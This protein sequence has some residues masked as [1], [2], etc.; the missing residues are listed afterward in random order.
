MGPDD[1]AG[2][3]AVSEDEISQDYQSRAAEFDIPEK[4]HLEQTIFADEASAKAAADQIK[5][6][7]SVADAARKATGKPPGDIGMVAKNEVLPAL[8]G[9]FDAPEGGVTGPVQPALGWHLTHVVKIQPAHKATLAEVHDKVKADI[10]RRKAVDAL[11]SLT[12]Q[13]DDDLASGDT[14]EK[15]AEK[16]RLKV[17]KVAAIDSSGR[18]AD[19]KSV[20]GLADNQPILAP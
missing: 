15:A 19:R 16:L 6:G 12:K 9:A 14:L 7:R 18:A 1:I 3:I 4:R 10:V 17:R 11:V 2:D 13:F 8:A 20:D 5:A